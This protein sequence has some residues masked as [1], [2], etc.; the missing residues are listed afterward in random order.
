MGPQQMAVHDVSE[1]AS[2]QPFSLTPPGSPRTAGDTSEFPCWFR[3]LKH[4]SI[5]L[6][7]AA[8][9]LTWTG[10]GGKN[11]IPYFQLV[12][13][14]SV[15]TTPW[16]LRA[17]IAMRHL[18]QYFPSAA[19][20][21]TVGL[22]ELMDCDGDTDACY[23]E[24]GAKDMLIKVRNIILHNPTFYFDSAFECVG[25]NQVRPQPNP[26]RFQTPDGL[27]TV[28]RVCGPPNMYVDKQIKHV[29]DTHNTKPDKVHL[30]VTS[31][32]MLAFGA[33]DA[34]KRDLPVID[35]ICVPAAFFVMGWMLRSARLL[36]IAGINLVVAFFTTFA[37]LYFICVG[38]NFTPDPTQVN[39]VSMIAL[40]L[41]FDYS[42]FL[43]TRYVATTD[44]YPVGTPAELLV[45]KSVTRML[46]TV[47]P[48]ILSSGLTLSLVFCG[49]MFLSAANLQAAGM[50]CA[51]TTF[52][53]MS[54]SL[55]VVPTVLLTFPNFFAMK[56]GYE[57]APTT[58]G[59]GAEP[60]RPR[61]KTDAWHAV[62]DPEAA[63]LNSSRQVQFW[64]FI[65]TWPN[66]LIVVI[67]L[68]IV[69]FFFGAHAL[70]LRLNN[71]ISEIAPR[72]DYTYPYETLQRLRDYSTGGVLY[73]EEPSP[74]PPEE[75]SP[76]PPGTKPPPPPASPAR[77]L[78]EQ[79]HKDTFAGFIGFT[80]QFFVVMTSTSTLAKND[81]RRLESWKDVW[82]V[83]A[84]DKATK[85]AEAEEL[86]ASKDAEKAEHIK[87]IP[88]GP[89]ANLKALK[90]CGYNLTADIAQ[91]IIDITSDEV[92]FTLQPTAVFS[93][94]YARGQVIRREQALSWQGTSLWTG[95]ASDVALGYFADTYKTCAGGCFHQ[96]A[97]AGPAAT[98]ATVML[99]V[100]SGSVN[101]NRWITRMYELFD[102][103]ESSHQDYTCLGRKL[104]LKL[105]LADAQG[106]VIN[107][108]MMERTF[109]EFTHMLPITCLVIF[110]MIGL[111]LRSAF[112]P[113]RL[114]MTLILPLCSVFGLSVL[115]FQDGW[116]EF[117]GLRNLSASQDRSFHWEIP[118]VSF[119]MTIALS[120][121]YD[122][123]VVIRIADYRFAGYDIRGSIIRALHETGPVVTGAGLMMA[124]TFGGNLLAESTTLNQGGWILS[125][126]VLVDTFI[127]RVMLVPAL[128]S[129]ADQAA[130]WPSRPP[131]TDL[132][133][134]F[135]KIR[136]PDSNY[137]GMVPT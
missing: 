132:L 9:W 105:Y 125:S 95:D 2:Q 72:G 45:D 51:V 70:G 13:W 53:V 24:V 103:W 120:L 74:P 83:D 17:N 118:V 26:Q 58:E 4:W 135:G 71:D 35:S 130:W 107:H 113:L 28:F 115:I 99:P 98:I 16:D 86:K 30:G 102:E 129:I 119:A 136:E 89:Q 60:S 110:L 10:L 81:T 40:G 33:V 91:S 66:N 88:D 84:L 124:I 41:N 108:D 78:V 7:L 18:Y 82:T 93:P 65:T 63:S 67:V 137:K 55:T 90:R 131:K 59:W 6:L 87:V 50:A 121:D 21:C 68:H 75:S 12:G 19:P 123:F 39:F 56:G 3:C 106:M 100:H 114:A 116:L 15:K 20:M 62:Q 47:C 52:V 79:A 126:G 14:Q 37:V 34:V 1:P 127:V 85:E 122:L 5:R 133:D 111:F 32:D 57:Q 8:F 44:H 96:P 69:A 112:V 64:R 73:N 109:A 134:E 36:L 80:D 128:L 11:L 42:L 97:I 101:G 43:L 27:A 117:L 22:V 76:P 38:F 92:G 31:R 49:F 77:Q 104:H 46:Q 25:Q 48:V 23:E 54:C 94:G 61:T 29:V